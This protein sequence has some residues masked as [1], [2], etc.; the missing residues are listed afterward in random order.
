L[1]N[2]FTP[3]IV[4]PL[5]TPCLFDIVIPFVASCLLDI[6]ALFIAPPLVAPCLFD[7]A[8][9]YLFDVIAP[10]L[11]NTIVPF[12]ILCL[13]N[14]VVVAPS[15][16]VLAEYY[17]SYCCFLFNDATPLGAQCCCSSC[18]IKNENSR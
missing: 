7:V 17:Y 6:V 3:L 11:F 5:A 10:Y 14:V 18:N 1:F 2:A 4:A 8:T 9:L 12:I 16:D 15:F 13:L